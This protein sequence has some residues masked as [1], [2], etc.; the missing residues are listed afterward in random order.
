MI[1][2]SPMHS[3]DLACLL[4]QIEEQGGHIHTRA[5]IGLPVP[6]ERSGSS[7]RRP[8]R[9]QAMSEHA[10][11]AYPRS[12]Y[13]AMRRTA[14]W[15]LPRRPV[16][17]KHLP[18]HAQETQLRL[19]SGLSSAEQHLECTPQRFKMTSYLLIPS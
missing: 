7:N 16:A 1:R 12:I 11:P 8:V 13:N 15:H 18:L 10:K 19:N 14:R 4:G 5:V 9:M 2:D 6:R 17:S 3:L